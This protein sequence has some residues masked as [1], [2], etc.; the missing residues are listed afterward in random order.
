MGTRA[1]SGSA[2]Q[3]RRSANY[4]PIKSLVLYHGLRRWMA[5]RHWSIP[6]RAR[7][8]HA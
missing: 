3:P 4:T 2:H 1:P 7:G 5:G 6:S 8:G